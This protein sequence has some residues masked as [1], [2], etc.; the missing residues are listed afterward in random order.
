MVSDHSDSSLGNI[1]AIVV[2]DDLFLGI[3]LSKLILDDVHNGCLVDKP[4]AAIDIQE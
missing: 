4:G 2:R 1:G 3:A